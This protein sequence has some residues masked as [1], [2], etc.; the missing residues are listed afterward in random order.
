MTTVIIRFLVSGLSFD[1]VKQ[2]SAIFHN[3]KI[4]QLKKQN[5]AC[6]TGTMLSDEKVDME[7]QNPRVVPLVKGGASIVTVKPV[8]TPDAKY[9]FSNYKCAFGSS[10]YFYLFR[11]LYER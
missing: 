9:E 4:S 11:L 6:A 10:S 7:K 1:I 3:N 2:I 8:I 5:C